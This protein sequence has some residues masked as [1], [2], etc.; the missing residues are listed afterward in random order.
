M[1]TVAFE[2]DMRET[3]TDR[4]GKTAAT[5]GTADAGDEGTAAMNASLT[6]EGRE[7]MPHAR[8]GLVTRAMSFSRRRRVASTHGTTLTTLTRPAPEGEDDHGAHART[9]KRWGGREGPARL[10]VLPPR[11]GHRDTG[12]EG[13]GRT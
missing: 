9:T 3:K 8:E 10:L 13:E 1:F 5:R 7:S 11:T 2:C 6:N 12:D 4:H